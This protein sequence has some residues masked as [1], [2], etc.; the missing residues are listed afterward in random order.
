[1]KRIVST[2]CLLL[3][4]VFSI[5][6]SSCKKS[7]VAP[8]SLVGSWNEPANPGGTVRNI[9]FKSGGKFEASFAYYS[10]QSTSPRY[11]LFDGTYSVNGNKLVVIISSM[12]EM[13]SGGNGT[14][15]VTQVSQHMFGNATF[16]INNNT[17]TINYT[18]YPADAPTA[19]EANFT[20]ALTD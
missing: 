13:S 15:A 6:I 1:M 19:T 14:P 16:K 4:A 18:T 11:T 17:L 5:G 9:T 3:V 10:P 7:G 8:E 2:S 12:I 20:R